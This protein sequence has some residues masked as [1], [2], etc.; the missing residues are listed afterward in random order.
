MKRQDGAD[1]D[2]FQKKIQRTYS[3]PTSF[4]CLWWDIYFPIKESVTTETLRLQK[5]LLQK[6]LPSNYYRNIQI[7]NQRNVFN[8]L[9]A[10]NGTKYSLAIFKASSKERSSYVYHLLHFTKLV[11]KIKA[12]NLNSLLLIQMQCSCFRFIT[13]YRHGLIM[14]R[15]LKNGVGK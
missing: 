2:K 3:I 12:V 9:I 1:F 4:F 11:R 7:F 13:I 6:Q 15:I 14:N 10:E 8:A 5:Q